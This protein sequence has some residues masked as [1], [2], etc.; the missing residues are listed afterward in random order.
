[1]ASQRRIRTRLCDRCL[2]EVSEGTGSFYE[3]RAQIVA[4]PT[5]PTLDPTLDPSEILRRYEETLAEL[6]QANPRDALDGVVRWRVWTLCNPCLEIWL[7]DPFP[8]DSATPKGH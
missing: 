3:I 5:P 6:E 4:D 2:K 7:D 8:R 1:M